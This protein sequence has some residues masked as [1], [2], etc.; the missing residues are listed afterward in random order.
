[1]IQRKYKQRYEGVWEVAGK[2][3][4]IS[5]RALEAGG[6]TLAEAEG[7]SSS[8]TTLPTPLEPSSSGKI[9]LFPRHHRSGGFDKEAVVRGLTLSDDAGAISFR[10]LV[11]LEKVE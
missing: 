4:E 11:K 1:M 9:P 5:E 10:N 2:S 3:E 8:L 6:E 7:L